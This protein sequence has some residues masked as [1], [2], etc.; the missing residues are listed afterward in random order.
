M[1]SHITPRPWLWQRSLRTALPPRVVG[2]FPFSSHG[3][4]SVLGTD[5]PQLLWQWVLR[6]SIISVS[7]T[8]FIFSAQ[9]ILPALTHLLPWLQVSPLIH[10]PY[11]QPDLSLKLRTQP[12]AALATGIHPA[13]IC[14]VDFLFPSSPGAPL[15][16][17]RLHCPYRVAQFVG[18]LPGTPEGCGFDS[19]SGHKIHRLWIWSPA[20]AC[21][22][23]NW[24]MFF[25][26]ID[27]SPSLFPPSSL[28]KT[29]E[30]NISLGYDLKKRRR[31]VPSSLYLPELKT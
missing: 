20:E 12:L 1:H 19:Q 9:F 4:S 6:P 2:T 29:N 8:L 3:I 24:S 16:K 18:V 7:P 30:K 25:S 27:V 21:T 14:K 5:L 10:Q 17:N 13:N 15:L 31:K 28:T 22:G 26:H 23:G 11:F